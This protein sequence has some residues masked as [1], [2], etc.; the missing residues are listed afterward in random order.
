MSDDILARIEVSA[1]LRW[2]GLGA[3]L[4]VG[5][6]LVWMAL[7]GP[8]IAALWR[9]LLL[10]L[11]GLAL[12]LGARMHGATAVGLELTPEVLRD[13]TGLVLARVDEIEAVERGAFAFKP[14]KGFLL[15]LK[16]K[17]P[18]AWMPGLW[19]RWGR[20]LGVGGVTPG[21]QTK[22]MAEAIQML[23]QERG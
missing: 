7:A 11:A 1:L 20:R 10:A 3:L 21:H 4:A 22:A 15:R 9:V 19:W 13:G 2:I 8:D 16:A 5:G 23:L 17:K 6:L 18:R 14:S 12:A